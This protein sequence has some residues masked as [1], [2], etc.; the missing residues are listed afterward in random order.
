[1]NSN[2]DLVGPMNLGN[3]E[4]LTVIQVAKHILNQVGSR[5]SISYREI[6][7]DDPKQRR[8][9]I[10]FAKNSLGWQPEVNLLSG[11]DLTVAYFKSH[12]ILAQ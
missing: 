2:K 11:L 5:S 9:D 1:M 3:P 4:E 7:L 10:S 6:P 12:E 8:P